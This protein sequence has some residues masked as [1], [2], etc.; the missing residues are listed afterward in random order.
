[1]ESSECPF[2]K[3][4]STLHVRRRN[5]C[6]TLSTTLLLYRHESHAA[7]FSSWAWVEEKCSSQI[8]V[9]VKRR[10]G[11]SG[12]YIMWCRSPTSFSVCRRHSNRL[13]CKRATD[14]FT[15]LH[16]G[17]AHGDCYTQYVPSGVHGTGLMLVTCKQHHTRMP[18]VWTERN[19][20]NE[21]KSC[22]CISCSAFTSRL[23]FTAPSYAGPPSAPGYDRPSGSPN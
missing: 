13:L 4:S 16:R 11:G 8:R 7:V 3:K 21:Q 5:K 9:P 23:Y 2:L 10:G 17:K 6:Y 20:N 15:Q 22:A 12:Q 19:G 18:R 1:M 14:C